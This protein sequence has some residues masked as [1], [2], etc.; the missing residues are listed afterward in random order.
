MIIN[1]QNLVW[2]RKRY[3][4]VCSC[5]ISKHFHCKYHKINSDCDGS[6]TN[7]PNWIKNDKA[8]TFS[9]NNDDKRFQ[10]DAT[11]SAKES[12]ETSKTEP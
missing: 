2:K 6:Y 1:H 5:P 9:K 7:S 3:Y 12:Q 8:T 4:L 10:Y 11:A